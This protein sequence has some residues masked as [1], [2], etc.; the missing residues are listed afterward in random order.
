SGDT[1]TYDVAASGDAWDAN[2]LPELNLAGA[3]E[4]YNYSVT[5]AGALTLGGNEAAVFTTDGQRLDATGLSG[6][7]TAT[8]EASGSE[9]TEIFAVDLGAGGTYNLTAS[10]TQTS[11]NYNLNLTEG[12]N[13][14]A[15]LTGFDA[16][17]SLTMTGDSTTVD[18]TNL[19]SGNDLSGIERIELGTNTLSATAAQIDALTT[20]NAET[21]GNVNVTALGNS[22]VDL[23]VVGTDNA[24][25]AT[26]DGDD[27]TLNSNT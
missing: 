23:T 14:S 9:G 20:L 4:G 26:I 8:L 11:G 17:D 25:T 12:G 15:T 5:G 7:L 18:V 13:Y 10:D 1:I 16:S 6:T 22:A 24:G 3:A 19:N 21:A 2:N 27:V